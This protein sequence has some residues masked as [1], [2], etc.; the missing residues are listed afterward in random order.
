MNE[1]YEWKYKERIAILE[2]KSPLEIEILRD[3]FFNDFK[4][5]KQNIIN[6]IKNESNN[7][8]TV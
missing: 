2:G 7:K 3:K 4:Q 1:Y 5:K 6:I 8:K